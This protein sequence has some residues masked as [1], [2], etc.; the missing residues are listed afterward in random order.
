MDSSAS[1]PRNLAEAFGAYRHREAARFARIAKASLDE[2]RNHLLDG[3]DRRHWR[4]S[5][6]ASLMPLSGRAIGATLGWIAHLTNTDTPPPS[7]QDD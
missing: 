1:A 6:I 7:W 5:D 4:E 3:I 2:T